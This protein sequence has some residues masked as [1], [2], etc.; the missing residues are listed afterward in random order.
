MRGA[1]D[2]PKPPRHPARRLLPLA[3]ALAVAVALVMALTWGVLQVQVTLAGFLNSESVWSK[4]QKQAVIDLDGYALDGDARD[5]DGFRRNAG[6]LAADRWG[7]DA[8]VSGRFRQEELDRV[9]V[10]GNV[11]PAAK[12][13]MTFIMRH[14]PDAPHIRQA[15]DAWRSTDA[16]LAELDGIAGELQRAWAAGRPSAG[17]IARQR[18][19]IRAINDFVEPRTKLFSVEVVRGA[20]WLGELLFWAV[21]G[22][23]GLAALLWLWM[24]RRTLQDIHGGEERYRLLFDSAPAA[25][26]MVDD[27]DGVVIDA[28]RMATQWTGRAREA[29]LGRPFDRLFEMPPDARGIGM[30]RGADGAARPVE[31]VSSMVAWGARTVRQVIV[32]DLSERFSMEQER[33]IAAEALASIA[34]GVIIADA[35]RRIVA[36]NAAHDR[37]TGFPPQSRLGRPLDETRSLP[38]GSPLPA[39]V[40]E[41]VD[42]QGHWQGEVLSRRID[43]GSYPELLGISAIR[44][45]LQRIQH[46]VA[47]FSNIS[48]AKANQQRLEHLATHDPLTG[49]VNRAEF[50][51]RCARAIAAAD[52]E[53][54]AVAVL[55]VDLD[56]FKVVN[57]SYSH[58]VGDRLLAQV[59]ERMVR[60][61]PP[62]SV[63]GRIG[64]DEF[65]VLVAGLE[66]R[67]QAMPL[68]QRLLAVL[69]EPL[70]VDDYEIVLSASIGIA[71]YPLDG[72]DA[73]MLI[74]N[75]DAAM[76]VAKSEE[77]NAARLYSPMMQAA[78]RRRLALATELRRALAKDEFR[79]VYQPSVELRSGRIVAVE[80]LLRWHHPERG[81]I[82][83]GEF[84]PLAERL[85]LIRHIDEWVLDAACAQMRRWIDAGLPPLRVAVN[86]SASW[87]GHP[88]FIAGVRERIATW[89]MPSDRL[90][91]EITEGAILQLGDDLQRTMR[92]LHEMGVGV[93]IDDFGTGY[94][95][96]SY[97]KL[98]AI[99]CLKIDQSFVAGLP[100]SAND[101]AIVEAML[102]LSGNL[103]LYAI[104][105]GIENEAQHAFLLRAG[106]AEGQ[107]YLYSRPVSVAEVERM[108]R[109]RPDPN[110]FRL[111]LVP[112]AG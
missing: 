110:P 20:V 32:R 68:A 11:M 97:L 10:Q 76:Y 101:A 5:L 23:F 78:A 73:T 14:F 24:A 34:E 103:G 75:A 13:G 81:E 92:A 52:A 74:A 53:R 65:T 84:I 62:G 106:C 85:G 90:L 95:S 59:A 40:W 31:A 12:P 1:A 41:T 102:A 69:S 54:R 89:R 79:L 61:L 109:R 8:I 98:P 27:A 71:G 25:I 45:G 99:A 46:Y 55:F 77:R 49:L 15:L 21:L 64:G 88:G 87:F 57:D 50:E 33:R 93:A 29:L 105:E 17:E 36:T 86:V 67:E 60:E 58:A 2:V 91:L 39:G 100:D 72:E 56:A 3:Y 63:A 94:S 47:V 35:G 16:P 44:D 28:N 51:R 7:R 9:F 42:R 26:L 43:G 80:A 30:L 112:P 96:L 4:A 18:G 66:A 6:L 107:G 38:D 104:A 19:R 22:A 82:L 48:V 111:H 70:W 37:I 108:L 83:P